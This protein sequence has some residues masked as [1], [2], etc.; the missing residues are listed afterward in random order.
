MD[1]EARR[2]RPPATVRLKND[3]PVLGCSS[4]R[5]RR[6]S[7]QDPNVSEVYRSVLFLAVDN[8]VIPRAI[9]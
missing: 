7:V 9:G 8:V 1:S 6:V 4:S 3:E 5:I 2:L